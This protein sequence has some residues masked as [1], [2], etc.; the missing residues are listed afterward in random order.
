MGRPRLYKNN[1]EKQAA[2]MARK[3]QKQKEYWDKVYAEYDA[4]HPEEN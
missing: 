4:K 3:R 2:Y 1:A